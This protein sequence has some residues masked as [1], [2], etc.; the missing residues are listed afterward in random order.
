MDEGS[1]K[2]E[3][4]FSDVWDGYN[5]RIHEDVSP[6]V[7][8]HAHGRLPR[9]YPS[10]P[11]FGI[12]YL[13]VRRATALIVRDMYERNRPPFEALVV[14]TPDFAG[15]LAK[16]QESLTPSIRRHLM[17]AIEKGR[18]RSV[19]RVNTYRD[20]IENGDGAETARSYIFYGDLVNW[21]VNSGYEDSRFLA[22]GPAFQEYE[23]Q[24]LSL[25]KEVE[26]FI[27]RR[28]ERPGANA[29]EP[30]E[31]TVEVG[32]GHVDYLED[33]LL[34][35]ADAVSGLKQKLGLEPTAQE[36]SPLHPKERDSLLALVAALYE[37]RDKRHT[38]KEV[39]GT[40]ART[41]ASNGK[42]LA[43]N[44]VRK[45]LDEAGSL[46]PDRTKRNKTSI[47]V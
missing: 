37:L 42:R 38:D 17:E 39:V 43:E 25:G 33:A 31:P 1:P 4:L 10:L 12:L 40:L 35:S 20:F 26:R 14:G 28:R 44:T 13:S 29:N 27:Q 21:L 9:A 8:K 11:S 18:L 22:V 47:E 45:Y 32:D 24:E 5:I 30:G 6:P 19:S 16:L 7:R 46:R 41:A 23:Q 15:Q 2:L 3:E 34:R 36:S